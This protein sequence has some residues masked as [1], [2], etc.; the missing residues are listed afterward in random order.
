VLDSNRKGGPYLAIHI[1]HTN[2]PSLES[3]IE[4]AERCESAR[5]KFCAWDGEAGGEAFALRGEVAAGEALAVRGEATGESRGDS[6]G[7]VRRGRFLLDHQASASGLT[8]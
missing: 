5:G 1:G 3:S 6:G 8:G 4:V 7:E 2:P